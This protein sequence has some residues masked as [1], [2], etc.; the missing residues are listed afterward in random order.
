MVLVDAQWCWMLLG[1]ADMILGDAGCCLV[2][3]KLYLVTPCDAEG[4]WVLLNA[5]KAGLR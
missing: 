3:P 1:D 4:C 2:V 5:A